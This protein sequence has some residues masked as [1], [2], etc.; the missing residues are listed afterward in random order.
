MKEFYMYEIITLKTSDEIRQVLELFDKSFPR[1][2]TTRVGNL[3]IYAEKLAN[4]SLFKVI[5]IDDGVAGFIVYYCNNFDNKKAF[6]SQIAVD[7]AKK[8]EGIGTLLLQEC[9]LTCRQMG[10]LTIEC[11]VDNTNNSAICFYKKEGFKYSSSAGKN[12]Q[13]LIKHL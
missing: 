3:S 12:S 13:Y 8:K 5:R 10:M 2:L 6:L 9:L 7:E 4:K 1:P 11:E